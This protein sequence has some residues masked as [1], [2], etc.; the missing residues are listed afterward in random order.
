[1]RRAGTPRRKWTRGQ[2]RY[3]SRPPRDANG[4]SWT[5]IYV[6]LLEM[7]LNHCFGSIGGLASK[8]YHQAQKTGGVAVYA[9]ISKEH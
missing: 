1:M 4:R 6:A 7:P 2:K 8:T 5:P 3:F 9:D